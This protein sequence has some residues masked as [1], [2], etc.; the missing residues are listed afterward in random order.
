MAD[1]ATATKAK[2]LDAQ[3]VEIPTVDETNNGNMSLKVIDEDG[4]INIAR[5]TEEDKAKY[6]KL[7][8]SLVTTDINSI[9]N[10]GADLQHTMKRYSNQF[11]STVRSSQCG[12]VG[13]L[14]TNL[15]S[16]L[17]YVNVDELE[18]PNGFVKFIRKVPILKHFV[19]S[20]EKIL[21]KYDSIEKNVDTI[22][23]KINAT[24][25]TALRDNNV[26]QTMFDQNIEYGK[27][28][29]E[30]IIAGKIK[31]DEINKRLADMMAHANDYEP[32]EIQ[33]IQEFAYNL[34][35]RLNDMLVL[36]YV[37]K[38]S[39]PQIRTVQYNNIAIANKARS[40]ISTTIP[41][42]KNQLSIAVALNNQK[43][44]VTAQTAV[45][46][47]TNT[48]LRRNAE[49]LKMN[50]INVAKETERSIVDLDTLRKT[51]QDLIDTIKEVKRIHEEGRTQRQ[52]AE[53]EINRIE[54]ELDN[55]M[56]TI[57]S[58][59]RLS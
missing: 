55:T 38:Q 30:L 13:E 21:N 7:N 47:A 56:T 37:T 50:S 12:E 53:I 48:I 16:E 29:E 25:L 41:L 3:I 43:D 44:S 42:W 45:S 58:Q 54:H 4:N 31:L 57:N 19:T 18:K 14:I 20:L 15:L 1:T 8:Q 2:I 33:D 49:L 46:E 59:Y 40:I 11:L 9:S 36:R 52:Q 24:S 34:D 5:L 10:F 35:K 32:H 6:A 17:S 26:L 23:N 39:L 51:T 22:S 28:I 27:Q